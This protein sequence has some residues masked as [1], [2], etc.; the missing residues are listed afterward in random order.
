MIGLEKVLSVFPHIT[1]LS[2]F[3]FHLDSKT[4]IMLVQSSKYFH[5]LRIV[6][7]KLVIQ[8]IWYDFIT[9]RNDN[10]YNKY[11]YGCSIKNVINNNKKLKNKKQI[12]LVV[13][14]KIR[15]MLF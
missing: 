15:K 9:P 11:L 7:Y 6:L 2:M 13:N 4:L 5:Q 12:Q 1:N 8:N 10:K 3:Y 14:N